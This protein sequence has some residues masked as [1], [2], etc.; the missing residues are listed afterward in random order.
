MMMMQSTAYSEAN[1]TCY[2]KIPHDCWMIIFQK[3]NKI[4]YISHDVALSSKFFCNVVD[5]ILIHYIATHPKKNRILINAAQ[6]GK[7]GIIEILLSMK[8]RDVDGVSMDA[9]YQ[10][11]ALAAEF[12]HLQ[13]VRMLLLAGTNVNK[14]NHISK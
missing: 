2:E 4:K 11:L 12:G 5:K 10:A 7:I 3:L 9:C 8:D 13:V 14:L 6:T 1:T